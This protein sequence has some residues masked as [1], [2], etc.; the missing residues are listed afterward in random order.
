[1]TFK[2]MELKSFNRKILKTNLKLFVLI[3]N[4]WTEKDLK[5]KL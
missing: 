4:Y 1:M 5:P 2:F 3:N